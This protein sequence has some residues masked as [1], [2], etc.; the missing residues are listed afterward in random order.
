MRSAWPGSIS[1]QFNPRLDEASTTALLDDLESNGIF[2][3]NGA[4]IVY[5][6]PD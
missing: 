5:S 4:K 3:R 1:A 2:K 6:L